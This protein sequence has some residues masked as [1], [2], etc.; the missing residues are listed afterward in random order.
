MLRRPAANGAALLG[1][2]ALSAALTGCGAGGS[3]DAAAATKQLTAKVS[4]PSSPSPEPVAAAP[5]VKANGT[6]AVAPLT[7]RLRPDVLVTSART[8]SPA[9]LKR[10]AAL[11]PDG[12][13]VVF[14]AG[15]VKVAG[16]VVHAVAVDPSAFRGFAAAG[17]A[18][19][20]AVWL[21]VARGEAVVS[22]SLAKGLQLTLG[23]NAPV[24]P[25][26]SGKPFSLRVGAFATTGVTDTD[27][28]VNDE[29]G[30]ALGLPKATG[31]LLTAGKDVD[32]VA[33]AGRVRAITGKG[34][35]VDLLTPPAANPVAFLTGSRAARAFGAF[36]YRYFPDGTIQPDARWVNENVVSASVPIFGRVTCHR[37]MVPQ[38]RGA[39][40]EVQAAGLAGSL[41]TYD[42]CYVPRFIERNPD[43][44]ISLHTWGI[45]IDMDASTNYRGIAGTMDPKIVEIFKRWGF[46]WGGDWQ[47]TDPMHFELGAL[48]K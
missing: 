23:G 38:L 15:T 28:I 34:G 2:L 13:T 18:E 17:T 5:A 3:D 46:R 43:R 27:L 1:C 6:S 26:T 14:R 48:I 47:Y 20:T 7:A 40:A 44:S 25:L 24:A 8:F 4:T 35:D 33:L 16:H 10:L 30:A 19:A 29:Q 12:G 22:H 41:H 11:S 9:G 32:P 39:L 42:G 37:L 21:S 36:S 31:M 45:A